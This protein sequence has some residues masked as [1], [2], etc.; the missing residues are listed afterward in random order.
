[1]APSPQDREHSWTKGAHPA[2]GNPVYTL[3][4]SNRDPEEFLAVLASLEVD[5]VV[6]VRRFPKSRFTHFNQDRLS[7]LLSGAGF[8]Y[9]HLG[10]DLGGY[11]SG[12][13]PAFM[14]TDRF[15]RGLCRLEE[16][17]RDR[18]VVILC[19]ERLPW[20]CHRRFIAREMERHG[21]MVSHVI[22]QERTWTPRDG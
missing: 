18:S 2:K 5:L 21:F 8:G 12:G 16:L 1:M 19:A 22:D 6:D 20:R 10:E 3:G 13:Y 7:E 9:V 15:R 4:T 17:A 14:S 11:R